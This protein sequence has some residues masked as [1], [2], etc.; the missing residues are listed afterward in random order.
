M[1]FFL[2]NTLVTSGS[3]VTSSKKKLLQI[4]KIKCELVL[5]PGRITAWTSFMFGTKTNLFYSILSL[6]SFYPWE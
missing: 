2:T 4:E 1:A 6:N 3:L 5:Q